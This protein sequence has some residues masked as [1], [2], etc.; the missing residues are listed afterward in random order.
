ME[1]QGIEREG[2]VGRDKLGIKFRKDMEISSER[3]KQ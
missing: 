1:T 3:R 2:E